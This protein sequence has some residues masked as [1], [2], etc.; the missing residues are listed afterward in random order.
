MG[1]MDIAHLESRALT[2]KTAGAKGRQAA[3]MGELG[4][5]IVLV[6]ELGQL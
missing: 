1:V 6:H 2:G 4:K 3:L 5:G